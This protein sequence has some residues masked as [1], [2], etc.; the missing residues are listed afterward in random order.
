MGCSESVNGS[1][2]KSTMYFSYATLLP[3]AFH[4]NHMSTTGASHVFVSHLY[5]ICIVVKHASI[6]SSYDSSRARQR[7]SINASV[8]ASPCDLGNGIKNCKLKRPSSSIRN[9]VFVL[10]ESA[11]SVLRI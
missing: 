9:E 7:N 4:P 5:H 2:G 1:C 10:L 3:P 8:E 11:R 6:L